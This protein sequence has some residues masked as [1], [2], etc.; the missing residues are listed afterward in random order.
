M[1][2]TSSE[3]A[4]DLKS[5][6]KTKGCFC[7]NDAE[8]IDT[9]R[10]V[11]EMF[12]NSLADWSEDETTGAHFFSLHRYLSLTVAHLLQRRKAR[13][14]GVARAWI[15]NLDEF[16]LWGQDPGIFDPNKSRTTILDEQ[17]PK[18]WAVATVLEA[19][20]PRPSFMEK[21]GAQQ[22]SNAFLDGGA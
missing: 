11:D 8:Q 3:S 2:A 9:P 18:P 10:D 1:T 15:N 17:Q 13:L 19:M 12:D 21:E 7:W 20:E 4:L 22:S 5:K 14:V 6:T 16:V